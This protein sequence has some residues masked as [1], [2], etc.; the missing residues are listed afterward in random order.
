[1]KKWCTLLGYVLGALTLPVIP[2]G[3]FFG[4]L[5]ITDMNKIRAAENPKAEEVPEYDKNEIGIEIKTN[6][7][8]MAHLP[9]FLYYVYRYL[10]TIQTDIM[11]PFFRMDVI[12]AMKVFAFVYAGI[13]I[14]Q[15][16]V[17]IIFRFYGEKRWEQI[18]LFLFGVFNILCL[19]IVLQTYVWLNWTA[20]EFTGIMKVLGNMVWIVGVM[21]NPIGVFFSAHF[22][23]L[24]KQSHI[25]HA[26]ILKDKK[27]DKNEDKKKKR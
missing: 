3:V 20:L 19:G 17:G 15:I 10:L 11:Y 6:A 1:M 2:A 21:L 12:I 22:M 18:I 4:V 27:K 13:Y 26:Q 7:L 16:V 24:L 23:K 9:L 5:F 25:Y 8:V 14:A